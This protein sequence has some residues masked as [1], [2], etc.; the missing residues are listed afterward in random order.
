MAAT[1]GSGYLCVYNVLRDS[2]EG[3]GLQP[4]N[5]G[6]MSP[7]QHRNSDNRAVEGTEQGRA[8]RGFSLSQAR[9]TIIFWIVTLGKPFWSKLLLITCASTDPYVDID[10][11]SQDRCVSKHMYVA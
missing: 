4:D 7:G 8:Q 10:L 11:R 2:P 1:I 3:C 5:A 6:P 9:G